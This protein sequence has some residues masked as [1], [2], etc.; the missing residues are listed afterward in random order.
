M[1]VLTDKRWE[2]FHGGY[3][4]PYNAAIPLQALE[5]EQVPEK[6]EAIMDELWQE[7]YHQGDVGI[8]SYMALP[9]L[10]RIAKK[11]KLSTYHIPALVAVIE[12]ARH[13]N[14]PS[15]PQEFEQEYKDEIKGI[16]EV[17]QLNKQP[18]DSVYATSATAA[19]AA[20]NG[21][22]QLARVIIELEDENL[23]EKFE[24]FMEYYDEFDEWLEENNEQ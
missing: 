20:V 1:L 2:T 18:W 12:V 14:N 16:L 22:I 24:K 11:N 19:I 15:I 17:I 3:K 10:I 6:I 8:A 23:S 4:V 9:H 13:I 7:L 5:Q 21:H